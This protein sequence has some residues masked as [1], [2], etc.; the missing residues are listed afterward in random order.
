LT[1][2]TFAFTDWTSGEPNDSGDCVRLVGGRWA[3]S[4]A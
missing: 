4:A 2:E 3:I 1:A